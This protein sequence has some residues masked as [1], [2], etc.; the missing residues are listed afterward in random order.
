MEDVSPKPPSPQPEYLGDGVYATFDGY[1]IWLST[2]EGHRIAVEPAVYMALK[3]YA[4]KVW[5]RS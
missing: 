1:H 2:Q 3:A 4:Q 5:G